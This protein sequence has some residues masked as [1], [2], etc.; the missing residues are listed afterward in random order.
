MM[1]DPPQSLMWN[2]RIEGRMRKWLPVGQKRKDLLLV[3]PK[4]RLKLG[5]GRAK[6]SPLMFSVQRKMPPRDLV[7]RSLLVRVRR[8]RKANQFRTKGP[9]RK[10]RK[11]GCEVIGCL[12][13]YLTTKL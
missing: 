7:L 10:R 1:F 11:K 12:F 8:G 2:G 13:A 5:S 9:L 4:K 6:A 3:L